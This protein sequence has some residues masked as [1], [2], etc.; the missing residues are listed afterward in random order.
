MFFYNVDENI[1]LKILELKY[2]EE[3][4]ALVDRD[5]DYLRQWLPWVDQTKSSE[6]TK[7]FIQTSLEA[8]SK[9]GSFPTAIFYEGE[10]AGCIGV[11]DIDWRSK[12]TSIGYWLSS[13]LQGKGIMT[14]SVKAIIDY[15][16]SDLQ[17]N[18]VEI[19][20]AVDNTR[21]R[22]IP[23]RLGFTQE[24]IIRR[25]EWLYDRYIDH[26]VYGILKDEWKS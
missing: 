13:G 2:T 3:F 6:D 7:K 9:N 19:R 21:S 11:H 23:E 22:S 25:D 15:L 4:F 26:V 20:A 14:K 8:F 12:K 1:Q 17:L 18:R 24:G 10:I 16:F 5:R